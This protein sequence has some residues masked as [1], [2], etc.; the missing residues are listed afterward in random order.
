MF[1]PEVQPLFCSSRRRL[2]SWFFRTLRRGSVF[3]LHSASEMSTAHQR[4]VSDRWLQKRIYFKN[5]SWMEFSIFGSQVRAR[6]QSH[7]VD[8]RWS[9]LWWDETIFAEFFR[10]S[11]TVSRIGLMESRLRRPCRGGPP[12]PGWLPPPPSDGWLGRSAFVLTKRTCYLFFLCACV[13]WNVSVTSWHWRPSFTFRGSPIIGYLPFEVLGTSGYDYYHPDDLNSIA[14]SHQQC[15][16][17]VLVFH[18]CFACVIVAEEP[19]SICTRQQSEG[20]S[21]FS[22]ADWR[23]HILPLQVSDQRA[24]VD[25][26]TNK[27]LHNISPVEFKTRVHRLYKHSCE[28]TTSDLIWSW[29]NFCNLNLRQ[30]QKNCFF[31][32]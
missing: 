18:C 2:N 27:I 7:C 12:P 9:M 30:Q 25:L 32:E 6:Q 15:E 11:T 1:F 24:A 10:P 13:I 14:E 5:E 19:R 21:T 28:V 3:L 8:L 29:Q 23:G 20:P 31:Q 16:W 22:D 26:V 17:S 4:N